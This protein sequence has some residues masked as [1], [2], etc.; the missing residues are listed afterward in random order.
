MDPIKVLLADDHE[1]V[2]NGI[3]ILLE[4]ETNIEVIGE[5]SNGEEALHKS[6]LLNPDILI[7]DIRM[8]VMNGIE[9]ANALAKTASRTKVLILSMHDDAEY[10]TKTVE[11]GAHGY[12]LKDANKEEFIKAIKTIYEGNKYFSGDISNILVSQYLTFK[13]RNGGEKKEDTVDEYHLTKREKQILNLL[14]DGQHNKE[15]AD[16]LGKSIR[17]VETHRFNIMKKMGVNSVTDLLRKI[18]QEPG[19]KEYLQN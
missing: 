5:A 15:I 1:I 11:S 16:H 14:H 19:L 12:V 7:L 4:N 18:D 13:N 10:I 8:P 2:R 6:L 3:K 9:A 17:T